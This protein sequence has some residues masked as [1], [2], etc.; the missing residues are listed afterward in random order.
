M[1]GGRADDIVVRRVELAVLSAVSAASSSSASA[2]RKP[3]ALPDLSYAGRF[4]NGIRFYLF[5]L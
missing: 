2:I 4:Q 3:S 5:V 1:I